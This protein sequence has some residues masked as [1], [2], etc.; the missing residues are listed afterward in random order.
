MSVSSKSPHSFTS[1]VVEG[2][3]VFMHCSHQT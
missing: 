1:F 3:I 2:I